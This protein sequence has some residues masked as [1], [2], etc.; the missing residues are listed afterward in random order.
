MNVMDLK[1]DLLDAIKRRIIY[2]LQHRELVTFYVDLKATFT[3]ITTSSERLLQ[4]NFVLYS[5]K[6][7]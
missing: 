3:Q 1:D 4:N 2:T 5:S 6:D 7:R